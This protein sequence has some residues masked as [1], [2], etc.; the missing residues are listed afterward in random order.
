M[1]SLYLGM[2]SGLQTILWD[3]TQTDDGYTSYIYIYRYS[4]LLYNEITIIEMFLIVLDL[5]FIINKIQML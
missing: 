5:F 4:R 3:L 2:P 1:F